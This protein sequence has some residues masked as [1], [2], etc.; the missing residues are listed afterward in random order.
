MATLDLHP[1]MF[2]GQREGN[3][4]VIFGPVSHKSVFSVIFLALVME[5][6]DREDY[7]D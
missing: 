5:Y 6:E 3:I 1:L 7:D 2:G 4:R